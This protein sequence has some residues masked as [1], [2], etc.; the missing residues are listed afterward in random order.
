AKERSD[1]AT[2]GG[3]EVECESLSLTPFWGFFGEPN[4]LKP[5]VTLFKYMF[6]YM[7]RNAVTRMVE[8]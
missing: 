7:F 5:L 8:L 4:C 3:S 6:K 1:C 2:T